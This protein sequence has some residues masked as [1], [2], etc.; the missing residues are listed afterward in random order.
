MNRIAILG[1][2]VFGLSL[3]RL[4]A[5]NPDDLKFELR[6]TDGGHGF[7]QGQAIPLE[8]VYSSESEKKYQGTF[9]TPT[10]E[11]GHIKVVVTP[12]EGCLAYGSFHSGMAGD[13]LSSLTYLMATPTIEHMDLSEWCQFRKSGH[14]TVRVTTAS[15][16]RLKSAE[17]GGGQEPLA[18]ES[19]PVDFDILPPDA[20]WA[21]EEQAKLDEILRTQ[22]ADSQAWRDALKHLSKL[23]TPASARRLVEIYLAGGD[24]R[25]VWAA[26]YQ[27]HESLQLDVVIPALLS[28]LTT[29]SV[30]PPDGIANLIADLQTRKKYP[31]IAPYSEDPARQ[32]AQKAEIEERGKVRQQYFLQANDL[33]LASVQ[34]R[35]GPQRAAAIYGAWWNAEGLR[36]T[37]AI[38]ESAV[39]Q[40]RTRVLSVRDE[41]PVDLQRQLVSAGWR[42]FPHEQLLPLVRT[43]ARESLDKPTGAYDYVQLWCEGEPEPCNAAIL[44]AMRDSEP[45]PYKPFALLLSES[46]RPEFDQWLR[47]WLRDPK[48]AHWSADLQTV[49]ALILRAGSKT[50]LRDVRQFLDQASPRDPIPCDVKAD[51]LGYL[52]RFTAKEAARRLSSELQEREGG[53]ASETLRTLHR[54]RYS[55]D[56]V[57]PA[58]AALDSPNLTTAQ[59][60]ALFLAEHGPAKVED[61][62][63]E[64]LES[65]RQSWQKR[66]SELQN[67]GMGVDDSPQ[68]RAAMLEQALASALMRGKNWKLSAPETERLRAGCLTDQCRTIADG[69]MSLG[70]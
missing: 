45:K 70:L 21:D 10:P 2:L 24:N 48:M 62:L 44:D 34:N 11:W 65:L 50:L 39:V 30:T 47:E 58:V 66:A 8:I 64:R 36:N 68:R 4:W 57:P 63:W 5:D 17:E 7:H 32:A 67:L 59:I 37:G 35:S 43:F 27:L 23:N 33:L 14:Y 18:L 38:S 46:E 54:D 53:C 42:L 28:A 61:A 29:P 31:V 9:S 20:G 69:K 60:A 15:I 6:L 55:D 41:L 40:L 19:N 1:F 12:A 13:F 52:Y 51:L 16:S 3:Q 56:L 49:A 22:P 26:D 25:I